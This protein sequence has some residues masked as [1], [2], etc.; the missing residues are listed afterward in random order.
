MMRE[1]IAQ[2]HQKSLSL[3]YQASQVFLDIDLK[4]Q[5]A[6]CL[7]TSEQYVDAAKIFEEIGFYS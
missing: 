3:F 6:Q 2:L 1:E 5:A 4:K 7:F